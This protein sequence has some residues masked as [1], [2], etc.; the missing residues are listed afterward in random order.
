[1]EWRGKEE[2]QPRRREGTKEDAK[3]LKGRRGKHRRSGG[4]GRLWEVL[5]GRGVVGEWRWLARVRGLSA[6]SASSASPGVSG[7]VRHKRDRKW[8]GWGFAGEN[9]WKDFWKARV[10]VPV[11]VN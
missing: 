4:S 7:L 6:W 2:M 8:A 1:M 10:G 3:R 5:G 11:L 9:A